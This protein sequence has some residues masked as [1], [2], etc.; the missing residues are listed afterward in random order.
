MSSIVDFVDS[1]RVAAGGHFH[2]SLLVPPVL[3]AEV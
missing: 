2:I 1:F 3:E